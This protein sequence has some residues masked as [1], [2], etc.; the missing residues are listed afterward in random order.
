M[1]L[2]DHNDV[3]FGSTDDGWTFALL[4]RPI[5]DGPAI[6]TSAGFTERAHRGR[7]IYLLPPGTPGTGA[8]TGDAIGRLLAH[9]LDIVELAWTARL[10]PSPAGQPDAHITVEGTTVT[11]I[12][13]GPRA[14]AILTDVGFTRCGDGTLRLPGDL[15]EPERVGR[16]V[17]AEAHLLVEGLHVRVDLGIATPDD[18]PPAP[19]PRP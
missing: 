6:M 19:V 14:H 18:L 12:A 2:V 3:F 7:T 13:T 4:N 8:R 11:A 5:A 10:A 9:T 17:R 16:I 1:A 15:D